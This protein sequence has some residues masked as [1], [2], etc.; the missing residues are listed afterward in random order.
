MKMFLAILA[1]KLITKILK[2]FRRNGTQ[3]PGRIALDYICNDILTRI[4][5]PK[6]VIAVSGSSGKG[7][8]CGLIKHVLEDNGYTVA[9]NETGSNCIVGA[10]TVILN[11]CNLKGEFQKDVL[12]LEC[13]EQYLKYIFTKNKPTHLVITNLTRDQPARNGTPEIVYE[14][15]MKSVN[16]DVHLVINADDPLVSRTK[17]THKGKITTFGIDKTKYDF[18]KHRLNNVDF[19]YCPNCHKKLKYSYYHYGHLGNYTCSNCDFGRHNLNYIAT[20]IDLENKVMKV[21]DTDIYL[22]KNAFYTAY[23]TLACFAICNTIGVEYKNIAKSLNENM[24]DS[25]RGKI[26]SF[27]NRQVM[28]LE[29][30]NENNLSYYQSCKYIKE[31]KGQKSVVLGFENVSRRYKDNDLSWLYD[32]EFELL[33]DDKI[34][35]IFCIGRFRYDVCTRLM[36]ANIPKEKIIL[37]DDIN[38]LLNLVDKKS[39]GD[40]YTMVCFDMTGIIKEMIEGALNDN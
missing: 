33:N 40:I 27:K 26:L 17:L 22:N 10:T 28:M 4:K 37:V 30:K 6:I 9:L 23:A 16:D 14:N 31:Q 19:A 35:K 5:Y 15:I 38:N 25:K 29:T 36:Y 39:K 21:N 32:V 8:T 18:T 13:D 3:L 1:N 2:L 7:T 34:D 24:I 20:N 11:N 12:L